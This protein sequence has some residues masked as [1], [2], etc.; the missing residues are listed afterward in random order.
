MNNILK[1]VLIIFSVALSFS[2]YAK[3]V[4]REN[5]VIAYI[6]NF[7]E[8]ITWEQESRWKSFNL[9]VVTSNRGYIRAFELFAEDFLIKGLPINLIVSNSVD[10]LNENSN[11][12][13]VAQDKESLY[14]QIFD[15]AEGQEIL[16]ISENYPNNRLIMFNLLDNEDGTLIFEMNRLNLMDNQ[17]L[18]KDELLVTG[19]NEVDFVELY[20]ESKEYLLAFE[21]KLNRTQKELIR[22]EIDIKKSLEELEE[23]K[24][25]IIEK[26]SIILNKENELSD[27]EDQVF[28]LRNDIES[29]KENLLIRSK[30]LNKLNNTLNINE[31]EL[32]KQ[33][34]LIKD[35]EN[36]LAK[37]KK[38]LEELNNLIADRDKEVNQKNKTI[39]KQKRVNFYL[40][41]IIGL[42]VLLVLLALRAVYL[43]RKKNK[44]LQGQKR[45]IE[46]QKEVLSE[47]HKNLAASVNYAKFIQK[48]V[49]PQQE[50]LN[51]FVDESMVLFKPKDV[52]SGD[53]YWWCNING[54][55]II[56]AVDCTGHGV[57]GA[58]LSMLGVS[59]LDKIVHSDLIFEPGKIL[60][61]LRKEVINSLNQELSS[62]EGDTFI[63]AKDG[64]DI[65]LISIDH[66]NNSLSFSGAFNGLY[67]IKGDEIRDVK[68][69]KMPIAIYDIMDS[70]ETTTIKTEKGD[71]FY[72]FS[73]GYHDQFGGEF[74]KKLKKQN[75]RKLLLQYSH[76]P[77]KEQKKKL[78]EAFKVWRGNNEQIDDVLVI[79]IKVK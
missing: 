28:N 57:P 30:E 76:L 46:K 56:A 2:G 55:T 59:L 69:D 53:F 5:M 13:F 64:M 70:F 7:T 58:F 33:L 71:Q 73:D 66:K 44:L 29:Q 41:F 10:E 34:N 36:T 25:V 75:F 12:I 48:S 45:E 42:I 62:Y 24:G 60:N 4:E 54:K 61:K 49:L 31:A 8:G 40:W 37:Q 63:G 18:I 35:G 1:Y 9:Q 15:Y 19:G 39:D 3:N 79:G 77:M 38:G 72:L 14:T 52:V 67:I 74:G 27:F 50:G 78:N 21:A 51:G 20:L 17:L 65:S 23:K 68:P 6:Y 47:T 43:N 26:E 22:L 16:L 32:A 11:A